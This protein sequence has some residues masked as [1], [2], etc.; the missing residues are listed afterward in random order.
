MSD[1]PFT[2]DRAQRGSD[3]TVTLQLRQPIK[4][5]KGE[6]VSTLTFRPL[7]VKHLLKLD[8]IGGLRKG[9]IAMIECSA[10]IPTPAI[11]EMD[12]ADFLDCREIVEDFL[13]RPSLMA[14]ASPPTSPSSST[15]RP[16]PSDD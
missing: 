10:H 11:E 15:G 6:S 8:E 3:G 14:P 1:R 5:I 9:V 12:G 7:K 13:D 16:A 2:S 4:N